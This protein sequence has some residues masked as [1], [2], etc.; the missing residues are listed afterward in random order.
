MPILAPL[1]SHKKPRNKRH[2]PF[3]DTARWRRVTKMQREREPTCR[4]C[5]KRGIVTAATIADH[6]IPRLAGGDE[7]DWD[8]LQSLCDR[9]HQ[10]KRAGEKQ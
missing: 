7:W 6:I 3:Y 9:C 4:E 10:V 5:R 8:N 2:D 1:Y